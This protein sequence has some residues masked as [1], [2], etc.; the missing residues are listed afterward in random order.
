MS[1][2][3]CVTAK[4]LNI[5]IYLFEPNMVIGRANIFFL[6]YAKKIFLLL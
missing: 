2:P 1:L 6:K 5:K 3:L 4:I